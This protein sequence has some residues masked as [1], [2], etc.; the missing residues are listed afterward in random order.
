MSRNLSGVVDILVEE[1]VIETFYAIELEFDTT[2][3]YLWTGIGDL[4]VDAKT[5]RG[6]GKFINISE[7][8]EGADLSAK[9]A[10]V[11]LSGI[12]SDM[13]TMALDEEYQGRKCYIRFGF[14]NIALGD[15]SLLLTEG[16]EEIT[17]E[18]GEPIDVSISTT[19]VL[20][21]LFT[22]YIDQMNIDEGPDTSTISISVE[23][24]LIDLERPRARR[25]TDADQRSRFPGDKAFEFV[26]RL[27]KETLTWGS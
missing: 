17:T 6:V 27:Q 13:L 5:Y 18:A 9:G 24:K 4:V 20:F 11:S 19:D 25:Y 8:Q 14:T 21:D 1:P 26:A 15:E 22:G 23:S 16:G 3:M 2:P 12:P 10:T 7:I